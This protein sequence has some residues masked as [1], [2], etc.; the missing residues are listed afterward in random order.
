V[1]QE[2]DGT[3]GFRDLEADRGFGR[4]CIGPGLGAHRLSHD[5]IDRIVVVPDDADVAADRADL[6]TSLRARTEAKR[7]ADRFL[8]H[9]RIA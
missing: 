5:H 3:R 9:D 4:V 8:A 6:E 2:P 7:A 1:S